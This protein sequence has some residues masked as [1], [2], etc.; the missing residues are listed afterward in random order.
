[1]KK[2]WYGVCLAYYWI[3][4]KIAYAKLAWFL[5]KHR[6]ND[7]NYC[8]WAVVDGEEIGL[9][10]GVSMASL[11]F[12]LFGPV[13]VFVASGIMYVLCVGF[14]TAGLNLFDKQVLVEMS[15]QGDFSIDKISKV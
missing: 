13:I 7:G 6:R 3:R 10:Q 14:L 11:L 4:K 8:C 15:L 12:V 2:V 1:M 5:R 9:F